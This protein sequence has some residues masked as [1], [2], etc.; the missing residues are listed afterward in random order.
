MGPL[1]ADERERLVTL[2][3]R[4]VSSLDEYVRDGAPVV[5]AESA[6]GTAR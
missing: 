6:N 3:D 1:A 5:P 4:F 2:L